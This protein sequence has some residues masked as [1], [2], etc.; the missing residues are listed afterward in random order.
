MKHAFQTK[1]QKKPVKKR[2]Y[3][4]RCTYPNCLVKYNEKGLSF[5]QLP[6]NATQEQMNNWAKVLPG[7]N[8]RDP[9]LMRYF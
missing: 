1:T 9:S 4:T 7:I 2:I 5:H 6:K 8:D 3:S